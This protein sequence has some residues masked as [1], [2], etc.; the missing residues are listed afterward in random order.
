[1]VD[2]RAVLGAMP[3][4]ALTT[5]ASGAG[6]QSAF[7]QHPVKIFVGNTPGG[8]DDTLS[9]A[10]AA[11]LSKE[12]G[13]A[14]VVE[15]RGGAS[16]TIAGGLVAN[17]APDGHTLLCLITTGIVQTVLRDKLPY[18]LSSFAPIVGVGGFPLAIVVPANGKP[19]ISTIEELAAASRSP[20]GITYTS[21]GVGTMAHLNAVRLLKA[22]KGKGVH[23]SY[24][25]NPEAIQA[26]LAGFAQMNLAS[27][28]EAAAL[29]GD[30]KLRVLAVTSAQRASNLPDV[31]TLQELGFRAF[32]AS[33]WYSYVAPAGTPPQIVAQLADAITR[34]VR[35]DEFQ[36]R[37]KP[38]AF[39]E[40][41]KTGEALS[42]VLASQA[43]RWKDVIL[44]E[45]IVVE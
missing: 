23:V 27:T 10:I 35:D 33:L 44:E 1:M 29:R 31:P 26:L 28:S 40:D 12:F 4:W 42:A 8:V 41:I 14:V 20:D 37:F 43:A 34:A 30:G 6:A 25:N 3:A 17:A 39:Q 15:N 36:N 13:Q 24:K 11:R 5:L 21:G 19:R 22:F 45:K 16:T 38:M 2:R 9:R 7:P 18:K 32:E